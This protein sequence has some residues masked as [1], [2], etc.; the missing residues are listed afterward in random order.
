MSTD[1]QRAR[2]AL[3]ARLRE[4]RTEAALSGRQLAGRL[5]WPHSKISKLETGRQTATEADIAGWAEQTGRPDLTDSLTAE[6]RGLETQYQS[7]QRRLAT[8]HRRAQREARAEEEAATV[9]RAYEPV[10]V[11]GMLQTPDYA[12][13][14]IAS[15]ADL[16]QSPKDV[17]D[18]VRERM[19]RQDLLYERGRSFQFIIWEG[20]LRAMV[21]PREAMASQ[22]DRLTGMIGLDT[23]TLG[24]IP[25]SAALPLSLRHG[26]WIHDEAYVTVETI[27]AGMWLDDAADVALYLRAWRKY[28][29]VAVYGDGAHRLIGQARHAL[30]PI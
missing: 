16:H 19:R 2:E 22:L 15:G 30:G 11:P 13:H 21:C 18:A 5:E 8:G 23:V 12:R 25:F 10:V 29:L 3:G 7:W 20:A 27:N 14:V 6:L 28:D 9:V 1:F 24:I 17:E 26:F 4:L